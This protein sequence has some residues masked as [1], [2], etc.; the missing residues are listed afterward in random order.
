MT[1]RYQRINKLKT[2]NPNLKTLLSVGGATAGT[3]AMSIMLSTAANRQTFINSAINFVRS[4]N[5]DGID[6][7]F[8]FPTGTDKPLFTTLL[9]VNM[10]T[11]IATFFSV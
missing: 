5:F 6:L 1:I 8:E 11:Q 2:I 7:D 4:R 9:Q 3:W 10:T